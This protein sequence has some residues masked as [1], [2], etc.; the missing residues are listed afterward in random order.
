MTQTETSL[1]AS[2]TISSDGS[3]S[4]EGN[5]DGTQSVTEVQEQDISHDSYVKE[6]KSAVPPIILVCLLGLVIY[7]IVRRCRKVRAK[8]ERSSYYT[9]DDEFNASEEGRN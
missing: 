2:P 4:N 3:V 7:F 9:Y 1:P 6:I 8:T 5:L